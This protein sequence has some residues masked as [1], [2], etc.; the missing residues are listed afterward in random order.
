MNTRAEQTHDLIESIYGD[1]PDTPL[2]EPVLRPDTHRVSEITLKQERVQ[3][4]AKPR[5]ADVVHRNDVVQASR[6]LSLQ[7]VLMAL[8]WWVMVL[9]SF[10]AA[11]AL[12]GYLSSGVAHA[13]DA[14]TTATIAAG[15]DTVSTAAV[16]A[17]GAGIEGNALMANPPV[18]LVA[19][20][21]KLAAP[22]LTRDMPHEQRK[23]ILQWMAGL[24]TFGGANN[25]VILLGHAAGTAMTGG[26]AA[27][28]VIIGLIAGRHQYVKAGEEADAEES[29][30]LAKLRTIE[31]VAMVQ[32]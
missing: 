27:V 26:L 20:G 21:L 15:T 17:T 16:V 13:A 14:E 23:P 11:S 5:A 8:F 7:N 28:P 29:A 9:V 32:P 30:R 2:H 25:I 3:V 22:R 12:V 19:S 24:W 18:F 4:G 1:L 10:A 31:Q 6:L